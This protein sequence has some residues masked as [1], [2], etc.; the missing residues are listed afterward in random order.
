[1]ELSYQKNFL[2]KISS[3]RIKQYLPKSLNYISKTIHTFY[4]VKQNSKFQLKYDCE[5]LK[6]Q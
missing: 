2:K 6:A 4:S 1:M 3:R 5:T